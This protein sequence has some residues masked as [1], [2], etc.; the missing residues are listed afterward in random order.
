MRGLARW[1]A[2]HPLLVALVWVLAIVGAQASSAFVGTD[3]RNSFALPGTD[4]QA[5]VDLLEESFPEAR[6]RVIRFMIVE[7][8]VVL[9]R[10]S[11]RRG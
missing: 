5:A 7:G 8:E 1:S 11:K 2:R 9:E 10:R 6:E 3:F 4:S